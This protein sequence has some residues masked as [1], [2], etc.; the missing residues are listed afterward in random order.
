MKPKTAHHSNPGKLILTLTQAMLSCDVISAVFQRR[1]DEATD[2]HD[3][4]RLWDRFNKTPFWPNIELS[5]LIFIV[6][7]GTKYHPKTAYIIF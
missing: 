3:D 1:I 4:F 7:F 5:G 2:I 6:K